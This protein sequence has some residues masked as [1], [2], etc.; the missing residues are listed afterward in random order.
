MLR[1]GDIQVPNNIAIVTDSEE[2]VARIEVNRNSQPMA[3]DGGVAEEATT[4]VPDADG[5]ADGE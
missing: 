1:A 2:M 3:G 5:S 4:N